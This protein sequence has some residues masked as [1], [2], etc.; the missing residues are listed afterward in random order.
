MWGPRLLG[1]LFLWN[2][3]TGDRRRVLHQWINVAIAWVRALEENREDFL[4]LYLLYDFHESSRGGT[5]EVNP[6]YLYHS[7]SSW[8]E[9]HSYCLT[10]QHPN[11]LSQLQ[12]FMIISFNPFAELETVP[13]KWLSWVNVNVQIMVSR[14]HFLFILENFT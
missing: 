10:K 1:T 14:I 5:K 13:Y 2:N 6:K 12:A 4:L 11:T 9:W 3:E 7:V 8:R